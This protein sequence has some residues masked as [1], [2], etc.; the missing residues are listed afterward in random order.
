LEKIKKMRRGRKNARVKK[1]D[2]AYKK[3]NNVAAA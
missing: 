3:E 2:E 1:T